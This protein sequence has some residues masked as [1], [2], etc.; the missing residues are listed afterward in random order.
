MVSGPSACTTRLDS[1]LPEGSTNHI[2][3]LLA[4]RLQA[5]WATPTGEQWGPPQVRPQ[6]PARGPPCK[7]APWRAAAGL[8]YSLFSAQL[9]NPKPCRT[10]HTEDKPRSLSSL[11]LP[12]WW[13]T[14]HALPNLTSD[15]STLPLC[16][17]HT[18][19]PAAQGTRQASAFNPEVLC[20]L[21]LLPQRCSARQPVG[22]LSLSFEGTCGP[23]PSPFR[24]WHCLWPFLLCPW[25]SNTL[26]SLFGLLS[27]CSVRM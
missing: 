23:S 26:D 3:A 13:S 5:E 2:T 8:R 15:C 9:L 11:K 17:G 27:V 6:M 20:S 16:P 12:A 24:L 7:Q 4:Q 18:R 25:S 1:G 21:S 10:P 14:P 19:L 22:F